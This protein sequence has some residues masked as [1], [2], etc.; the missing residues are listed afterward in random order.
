MPAPAPFR[1][2]VGGTMQPGGGAGATL[3]PSEQASDVELK[4]RHGGRGGRGG[5]CGREALDEVCC[6][7]KRHG[8]FARSRKITVLM[9]CSADGMQYWH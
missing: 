7:C 2:K 5:P 8:D 3:L 1:A 6:V 9:N 4:A